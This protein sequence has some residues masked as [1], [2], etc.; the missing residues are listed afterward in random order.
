MR[1]AARRSETSSYTLTIGVT[2]QA[3]A[4]IAASK[5]ALI[6]DTRYHASDATE[7]L[8][9]SRDG[10]TTGVKF[11]ADERYAIQDTLV[12]GG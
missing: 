5:N 2:G 1:N 11:G 12:R 3:L 9:H 10:D 8:P 6:S 4:P 7:S